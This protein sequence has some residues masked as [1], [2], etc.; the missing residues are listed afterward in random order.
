MY[1]VDLL[2]EPGK[3]IQERPIASAEDE[4]AWLS[5]VLEQLPEASFNIVGLSIGGW[6]AVT[7]ALH[8]PDKISTLVPLDSFNVFGKIP[9]KTALLSLPAA[10]SWFPRS[11][12]D[13]FNS[14]TANGAPVEDVPVADLIEA[15]MRDCCTQQSPRRSWPRSPRARSPRS[16]AWA[17][18]RPPGAANS[19]ATS[20]PTARPTAAPKPS[21]GLIEVHRRIARGFLNHDNYRLRM[22]LIAGGL[23][24]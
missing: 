20:T 2:G 17:R 11:W 4:A 13:G 6:T 23:N 10:V 1:S 24:L 18:P 19:S 5:E 15:G 9:L 7:L 22:L 21:T 16:P 14:Y 12:R 3:S 8:H